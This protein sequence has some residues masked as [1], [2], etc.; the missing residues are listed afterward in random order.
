MHLGDAD[1]RGDRLRQAFEE[2]QLDDQSLSLVERLEARLD[3]GAVLDLVEAFV[4][5]AEDVL[6]HLAPSSWPTGW[7]SESV[8]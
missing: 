3:E 5:R 2:A 1:L 7:E 4:H 6:H 8:E